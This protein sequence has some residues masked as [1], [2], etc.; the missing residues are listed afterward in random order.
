[1]TK[2]AINGMGRIGRAVFKILLETPEL[3]LVAVNDLMKP[4]SI[5]YLLK[6]DSVYGK[7]H[8]SI[9][10]DGHSCVIE[11]KS[12]EVLSEKD[13]GQ[14]PWNDRNIDIVF[15]CTGIFNTRATLKK[16]LQAGAGTVFLSA[17]ASDDDIVTVVHGVNLPDAREKI[18]SCASCTTNCITPVIEILG[19]RIGIKK[20]LLTTVHAY[21]ATQNLVDGFNK[22][23]R[24]G[25]AGALNFVPTSSGAARA[26]TRVL[27]QYFDKFD[28]VAVRAPI[29]VGSIADM[30]LLSEKE[31]S[32]DE[33]NN[34]MKEESETDRYRG[35]VGITHD[36][37]VSSDMIGD[38]RASVIDMN[39][40]RVVDGDLI[41]LMCWYDNEWGYAS[42]MVREAVRLSRG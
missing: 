38:S 41:K 29:P 36:P 6:Y 16:H 26:T 15:E 21:T 23:P 34:I 5:A 3:E 9:S 24:R 27:P 22:K 12:Y 14:L 11:D 42:Q 8:R 4:D 17:P 1:M 33:V 40:T 20:A 10:V 32:V 28:G 35:I 25:R 7:Y 18:I 13:P 39:M 31:T 30:V 37:V 2:V 19:R